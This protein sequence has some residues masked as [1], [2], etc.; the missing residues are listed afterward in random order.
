MTRV[1]PTRYQA[2]W[3]VGCFGNWGA[4]DER[5]QHVQS[6]MDHVIRAQRRLL[7]QYSDK[8]NM[9]ALI[10]ASVANLQSIEDAAQSVLASR[11]LDTSF[12][13][14]LS[15]LGDLLLHARGGL[16]DNTFRHQLAGVIAA[17]GS[18]C[19]AEEVRGILD[20]LLCGLSSVS[21]AEE[22]PCVTVLRTCELTQLDGDTFAA[23]VNEG[24]ASGTR[25]ILQWEQ[26]V[27]QGPLFGFES[28]NSS[29]PWAEFGDDLST[30]GSWAEA[31]D[32][33]DVERL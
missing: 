21:L 16:A 24:D 29:A 17:Q 13:A 26:P 7:A 14:T 33:R 9:L 5:P 6:K 12:G 15:A 10:R 25:T 22:P 1:D 28:D 2:G 31:W 3:G 18:G 30:A 19:T 32:G 20:A 4:A 11:S 8:P 23:I 27:D